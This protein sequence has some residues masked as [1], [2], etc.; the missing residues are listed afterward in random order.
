MQYRIVLMPSSADFG[1]GAFV[2]TSG[3]WC[4]IT[5]SVA[6]NPG[7]STNTL[8]FS[9]RRRLNLFYGYISTNLDQ[10]LS[11]VFEVR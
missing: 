3:L 4:L 1:Y 2:A 6:Q 5:I 7:V 9:F 10:E 8:C 11:S